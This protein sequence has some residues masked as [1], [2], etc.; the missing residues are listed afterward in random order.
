MAGLYANIANRNTSKW[1]SCNLLR[2]DES[3]PYTLSNDDIANLVFKILKLDEKDIL[4]ID[5]HSMRTVKIEISLKVDFDRHALTSAVELKPGI[6]V[7]PMKEIKKERWVKLQWIPSEMQ[8]SDIKAVMNL[9]G[10]VMDGPYQTNFEIPDNA[11]P[12]TKKLRNIKTNSRIIE[13]VINRNIPSYIKIKKTRVKVVYQGQDFTCAKCLQSF[14]HCPK[15]AKAA[16]CPR[17]KANFDEWWEKVRNWEPLRA[18]IHENDT[19]NTETIR[20]FNFPLG[21][22]LNDV[23]DWIND[24]CNVSVTNDQVRATSSPNVFMLVHVG[25]DAMADVIARIQGRKYKNKFLTAQPVTLST[26]TRHD[27]NIRTPEK[28]DERQ[29]NVEND[30]ENKGIGEESSED[31]DADYDS[32]KSEIEQATSDEIEAMNAEENSDLADNSE[33]DIEPEPVKPNSITATLYN[34]VSALGF[35][36]RPKGSVDVKENGKKK[37]KSKKKK[38]QEQAKKEQTSKEALKQMVKETREEL[39]RQEKQALEKQA[40]KEKDQASKD[41][42][43][44]NS[45]ATNVSTKSSSTS[46]STDKKLMPPPPSPAPTPVSHFHT[47]ASSTASEASPGRLASL[48]NTKNTPPHSHTIDSNTTPVNTRK[49]TPYRSGSN[50]ETFYGTPHQISVNEGPMMSST[51]ILQNTSWSNEVEFANTSVNAPNTSV[52]LPPD[53]SLVDNST[54][55]TSLTQEETFLDQYAQDL[56]NRLNQSAA[57][58]AKAPANPSPKPQRPRRQSL[59]GPGLMSQ[60]QRSLDKTS[61]RFETERKEVSDSKKRTRAE[62]SINSPKMSPPNQKIKP[63][64]NISPNNDDDDFQQLPWE[65]VSHRRNRLSLSKSRSRSRSKSSN[66][67]SSSKH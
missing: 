59:P 10:E 56:E 61:K 5:T 51:A 55:V 34:A 58:V 39:E 67:S 45:R 9:F 1:I 2:T 4:S 41:A 11:D 30:E 63:L 21:T 14:K 43:T 60:M 49:D 31:D 16:E 3:T 33:S 50:K 65:T 46:A 35:G 37:K 13:M 29:E 53:A 62:K 19:F 28:R 8:D 25:L 47:P 17:V 48:V 38:K 15:N 36:T 27:L 24:T 64:D 66:V 7:Q 26:P 57:P 20:I 23:Y 6:L 12:L 22:E 40:L 42:I 52:T 44:P 32:S 18:R 54:E